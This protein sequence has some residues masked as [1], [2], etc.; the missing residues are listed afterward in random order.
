MLIIDMSAVKLPGEVKQNNIPPECAKPI[1]VG[2]Y[3]KYFY[4]HHRKEKHCVPLS[5]F[6]KA[7]IWNVTKQLTLININQLKI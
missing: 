1:D 5:I 3:V 4:K 2:G 6:S 7:S